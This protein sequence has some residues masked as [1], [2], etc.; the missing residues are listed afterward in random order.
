MRTLF[1]SLARALDRVT[2]I[3][4]GAAAVVLVA[5]VLVNVVLRYGFGTGS[6]AMQDLAGYAFA[7]FVIISLPV[8]MARG[9]HVRVEV[10]SERMGPGYLRAADA[11]ALVVFLIPLFGL[12]V[13]AGWADLVYS[14]RVREGSVTPGGLGGLYLVKTVLPVAAVLM[15]IQGIAAVL[16]PPRPTSVADA[17]P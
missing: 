10:L 11:V 3:L 8:C 13:W 12:I 1:L 4:C 7:V 15:I 14:W 16:E 5:M 17:L 6:I 9:G 2:L